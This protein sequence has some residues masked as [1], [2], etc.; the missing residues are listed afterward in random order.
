MRRPGPTFRSARTTQSA[1]EQVQPPADNNKSKASVGEALGFR[2]SRAAGA[3]R[4]GA[5]SV[6]TGATRPCPA[7]GASGA[8]GASS[9]TLRPIGQGSIVEKPIACAAELSLPS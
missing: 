5:G 4:T 9:P 1:E 2:K 8:V 7:G 6:L 3:G